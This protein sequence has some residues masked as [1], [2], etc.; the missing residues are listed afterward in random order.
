MRVAFIWL[1][2]SVIATL[3]KFLA[4]NKRIANAAHHDAV[5]SVYQGVL[6]CQHA[7]GFHTTH[8]HIISFKPTMK[9]GVPSMHLHDIHILSTS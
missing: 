7:I 8:V 1:E 9:H 2:R 6:Y 4:P 3:H 5:H